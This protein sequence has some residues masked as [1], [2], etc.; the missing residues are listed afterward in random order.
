MMGSNSDFP[1]DRSKK[2]TRRQSDQKDPGETDPFPRNTGNDQRLIMF[3]N[4]LFDRAAH[5]NSE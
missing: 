1:P 5:F 3:P 4:D 2:R